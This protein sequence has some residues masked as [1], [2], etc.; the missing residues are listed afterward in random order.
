MASNNSR[1]KEQRPGQ[2][3]G[4]VGIR[5]QLAEIGLPLSNLHPIIFLK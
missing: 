4:G 2:L 3:T 1:L 5:D